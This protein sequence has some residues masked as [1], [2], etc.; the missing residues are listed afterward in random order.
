MRETWLGFEILRPGFAAALAVAPL[1]L[2]LAWYGFALRAR[3]RAALVDA[4][5]EGTTFRGFSRNRA[6]LRVA[7]GVLAVLFASFA[8]LGPARGFTLRDVQRRGL[9]IVVCVDTSR[10]MLAQDVKPDR[11]TR[12]QREVVGLLGLLQG[13]RAAL[14]A[15]AGDVRDVAPLTHDRATLEVF[16]KTLSPEENLKGGTD[17]G[18]ALERALQLFDGRTGAHEAVVVITDGEDLEARGLEVAK[19]A[20][21]RGIRVY[22]VGMGTQGGGKIPERNGFVRDDEGKEVVTKLSDTTL[23]A[24]ADAT[25]GAYVSVESSPT[26]LEEIYAKRIRG[27]EAREL[28]AGKERVPHDRFQWPLVLAAALLVVEAALRE[29]RFGTQGLP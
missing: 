28:V 3:A 2:L 15:F 4:G 12:A 25:G 9:D 24:I 1:A 11:L 18:A 29:R 17:I 14:L 26:P 16:V 5:L 6:R 22:V 27:L 23:R 10:S 8:L 21:E 13:D 19:R 7:C 20:G